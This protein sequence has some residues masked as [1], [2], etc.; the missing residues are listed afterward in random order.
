M[1]TNTLGVSSHH[2]EDDNDNDDIL[3][4]LLAK[5]LQL[6]SIF[7]AD[8]PVTINQTIVRGLLREGEFF[9]QKKSVQKK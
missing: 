8:P 4:F 9:I 3:I 1:C 6:R 7:A 5:S 2:D